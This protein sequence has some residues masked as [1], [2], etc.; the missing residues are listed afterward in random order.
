MDS[1]HDRE[2]KWPGNVLDTYKAL[3]KHLLFAYK[4]LYKKT[5]LKCSFYSESTDSFVVTQKRQTKLF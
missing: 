4:V 2:L 3:T 1:V 5:L